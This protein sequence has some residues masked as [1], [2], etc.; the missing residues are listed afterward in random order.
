MINIK[1][2]FCTLF[3]PIVILIIS[4]IMRTL[5]G[6][7]LINTIILG[8]SGL[9]AILLPEKVLILYGVETGAGISL[10]AQYAGLGSVAIALLTWIAK[11]IEDPKTL[12]RIVIVLILIY[13]IGT[14]ISILG[15]IS[16]V[17]P[18]G[19]PVVGLYALLALAYAYFLF[20]L[21]YYK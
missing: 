15:I 5:K 2:F 12:K 7:F 20:V 8:A 19:W 16:G 14:A 13:F 21:K 1:A 17:M 10:M 18:I 9:A 4:N 3:V 6:L 11:G